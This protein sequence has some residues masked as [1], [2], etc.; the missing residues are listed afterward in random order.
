LLFKPHDDFSLRWINEYN[1]EDS[2]HG[3]GGLRRRA[4]LAARSA[5]R[6]PPISDPGRD[7][8][9]IDGRQHVSVHQGGSSVE[10]NWNLAGDFTL[11]SISA[12]RYW[13]FTPANDDQLNVR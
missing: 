1:E 8:V 12:Y 11:T 5:G 6:R 13:H 3:S 7:K 9:N 4:V 10:A 2:S